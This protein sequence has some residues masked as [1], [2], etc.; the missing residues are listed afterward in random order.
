MNVTAI[1]PAAG[2]GERMLHRLKKNYIS[3]LGQPILSRTLQALDSVAS[4]R[5]MIVAVYPGEEQLCR[6]EVLADLRLRAAVQLVAGGATRQQ[7]VRNALDLVPDSADIVVIHDGARPLVSSSLIEEVIAA[8]GRRRAA[9]A[10][11][12]VKDTMAMISRESSAITQALPREQLCI[13]QTPQAFERALLV[14]A[15]EQA[16]LDGFQGTDDASLVLRLGI[17]V[18]AVD[19][20]YANIKITTQDDLMLAEL[21]LKERGQP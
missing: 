3:L 17:P 14:R 9:T 7:S 15:H 16:R 10:A 5:Q 21:I 6:Q 4:I 18:A 8:A 13:I 12:A 11:A 19:G 2:T 20:S 1:V